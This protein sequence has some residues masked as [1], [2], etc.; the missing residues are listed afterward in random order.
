MIN[1]L[2]ACLLFNFI[3]RDRSNQGMPSHMTG[4]ERCYQ[5]INRKSS[6]IAYSLVFVLTFLL[7]IYRGAKAKPSQNYISPNSISKLFQKSDNQANMKG[8]NDFFSTNKNAV[9][10]EDSDDSTA[11]R[12]FT[13]QSLTTG[14]DEIPNWLREA[15]NQSRRPKKASRRKKKPLTE[16]W[17]LWASL[18][19]GTG[20]ITAFYSMYQQTGGFA[21]FGQASEIVL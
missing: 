1:F 17:R 15:N 10:N 21:G 5:R 20:F 9:E 13:A 6:F 12:D 7:R 16:D 19:V 8:G 14:R 3:D 18:I 11:S 4:R 2:Q